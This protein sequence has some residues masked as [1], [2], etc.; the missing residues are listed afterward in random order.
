M[1]KIFVKDY[2]KVHSI[3]LFSDKFWITKNICR[4]IDTKIDLQI[5][6]FFQFFLNDNIAL[7][8]LV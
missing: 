4:E 3:T 8:Y 7:K 1:I 2:V 5:L 6:L